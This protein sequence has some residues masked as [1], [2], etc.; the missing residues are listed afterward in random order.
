MFL[1][2]RVSDRN[3]DEKFLLLGRLPLQKLLHDCSVMDPSAS[4]PSVQRKKSKRKSKRKKSKRRKKDFT[5]KA[6]TSR[7]Y[8]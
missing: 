4:G 8:S 5:K 7:R 2:R 3:D 1:L 6:R